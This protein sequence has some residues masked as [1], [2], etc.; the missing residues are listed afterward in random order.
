MKTVKRIGTVSYLNCKHFFTSF[1]K[2]RTSYRRFCNCKCWLSTCCF[3]LWRSSWHFFMR[4]FSNLFNFFIKTK[5]RLPWV[6]FSSMA[7]R[8]WKNSWNW[9]EGSSHPQQLK[10]G[11]HITRHTSSVFWVFKSAI[12]CIK[13]RNLSQV[14]RNNWK[15]SS[16]FRFSDSFSSNTQTA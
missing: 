1:C 8:A 14:F 2:W 3:T 9:L 16:A 6:F 5:M 13:T 4:N 12:S 7:S 10:W 11:W 15:S